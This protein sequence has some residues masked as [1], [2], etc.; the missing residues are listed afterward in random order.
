MGLAVPSRVSP[1]I[2]HTQSESGAMRRLN[3]RR[4]TKFKGKNGDR[5]RGFIERVPKKRGRGNGGGEAGQSGTS[6]DR[7][8][9]GIEHVRVDAE[10]DKRA[11]F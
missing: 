11:I 4:K 1:L 10:S 2:L 7:K 5:E 8:K 3:P 6:C 9:Q